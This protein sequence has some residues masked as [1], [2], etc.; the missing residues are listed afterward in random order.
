M[1]AHYRIGTADRH[2]SPFAK[3]DLTQV[4]SDAYTETGGT[5]YNL[6]INTD[7]HTNLQNSIGVKG[8]I[9][10][11]TLALT[12]L[13]S[14]GADAGSRRSDISGRFADTANTQFGVLGHEVSKGF[15]QAGLGVVYTPTDTTT[16]SLAYEGQWRK[17]Y[18]NQGVSL[19]FEKKF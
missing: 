12:G 13:L 2:L 9:G 3:I 17:H 18:D 19:T 16:L 14:V 1:S 7:T 8:R 4:K 11:P 5:D 15:G 10:S 6:A